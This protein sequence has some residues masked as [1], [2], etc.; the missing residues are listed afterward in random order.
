M[1]AFAYLTTLLVFLLVFVLVYALLAKTQILG[2][3]A[4]VHLLISLVVAFVFIIKPAAKSYTLNVMPWVVVFLVS[5][6]FI[7]LIISFVKGDIGDIVKNPAVSIGLIVVLLAIFVISG[8]NIVGPA[9]QQVLQLSPAAEVRD[10]VLHPAVLG[11]IGLFFVAAV[12]AWLLN[13]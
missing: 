3:N 8:M 1:F 12:V 4:A 2:S 9:L 10:I 6:F 13:K 5:V 7:I 11:V